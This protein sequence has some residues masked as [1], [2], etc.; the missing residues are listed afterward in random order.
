MLSPPH[1]R[2]NIKKSPKTFQRNSSQNLGSPVQTLEEQVAD[3]PSLGDQP[4]IIKDLILAKLGQLGD[5]LKAVQ[6]NNFSIED[7]VLEKL[8]LL[9]AFNERLTTVSQQSRL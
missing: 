6:E 8:R 7:D 1:T 5:S 3:R 9:K 2:Q 4:E